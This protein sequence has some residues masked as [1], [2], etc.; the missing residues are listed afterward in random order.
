[1]PGFLSTEDRQYVWQYS[2]TVLYNWGTKF[3]IKKLQGVI[4]IFLLRHKED[5][6]F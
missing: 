6:N 2:I 3:Q 1:M 4:S 5:L